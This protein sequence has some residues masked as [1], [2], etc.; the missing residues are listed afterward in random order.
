M[1]PSS[2]FG[3]GDILRII[4]SIGQS[5]L[6][7]SARQIS[8]ASLFL[9]IADSGEFSPPQRA[10]LA[11]LAIAF[12]DL[13]GD[14]KKAMP[15]RSLLLST[16][17][18]EAWADELFAAWGKKS[19]CFRSSGSTGE[20][21]THRFSIPLLLDELRAASEVFAG[22]ERIVSV[23]P[24]HHIFG[25][26]YG[27]LL[28]KYLGLPLRYASP[29]PLASFFQ[30]LLPG[31]LLVAFPFFWQALLDMVLCAGQTVPPRFPENI[32]GLTATSPCPPEIIHRLIRLSES[33]KSASLVAMTEIY[34]STETNGI[35]M[36][37]NGEEWYELFSVWETAELSDG[38]RG[39][40][41]RMPRDGTL[42]PFAMPDIMTWHGERRFTPKRRVDNAVQVGG[43]NVYPEKVAAVI[44]AHPLVKDCA[45]RLMRPDEGVRLKAFIVPVLPLEKASSHFDREFKDWLA[46]RLETAW[47]PKRIT[48]GTKLPVNAIG[49]ASDW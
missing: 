35:G 44:R 2:V 47:R 12:F 26:M 42:T 15:L 31:D 24:V 14:P 10:K 22:R 5:I 1:T 17:P 48:L 20:P 43:I 37:R 41:R 8:R 38:S 46:S 40:R 7:D 4:Q 28:S 13:A 36:R 30:A 18:L 3:R 34:G 39:I 16:G 49:K 29:L 32:A 11:D 6:G 21:R 23:M 45:V 9:E 33:G 19:I 25:M 27:P